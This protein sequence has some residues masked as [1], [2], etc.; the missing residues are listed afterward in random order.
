MRQISSL[1]RHAPSGY[2]SR[3]PQKA[4][5]W[6]EAH[7]ATALVVA[8]RRFGDYLGLRTVGPPPTFVTTIFALALSR[9]VRSSVRAGELTRSNVR[10]RAVVRGCDLLRGRLGLPHHVALDGRRERRTR[11]VPRP[12]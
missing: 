7:E 6:E 11:K 2:P 3:Q 9:V 12:G 4:S 8:D 1:V 5:M 10:K